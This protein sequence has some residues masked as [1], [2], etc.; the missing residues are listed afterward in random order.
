MGTPSGTL[1]DAVS[2][3]NDLHGRFHGELHTDLH[4]H[5]RNAAGGGMVNPDY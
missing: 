2:Y 1:T 4:G 5:W 3:P